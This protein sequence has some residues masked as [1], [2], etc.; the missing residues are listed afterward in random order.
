MA[1]DNN[2]WYYVISKGHFAYNSNLDRIMFESKEKC[3]I[4]A[5]SRLEEFIETNFLDKEDN[6]HRSSLRR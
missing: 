5:E 3:K 6:V 2:T 1:I 4:A